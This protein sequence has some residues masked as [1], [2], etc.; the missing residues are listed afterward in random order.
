MKQLQ[1]TSFL[2]FL[3]LIALPAQSAPETFS[4]AKAQTRDHVYFDQTEQGTFYCGCEWRWT[5]RSGG[6]VDLDSCGYEIRAQEHRAIRIEWEH[7]VPASNF[8]RARQCW[9]DGGRSNCQRTD[10]VFSLME[11]D[12]HNLAP[13]IGEVNADRSNYNFSVLPTAPKQHGACDFKVDFKDRAAE[14]RDEVKGQVARAYFY[15]FDRYD[16]QMSRQQEQLLMAWDRQFPVSAWELERDRRISPLMG[17]SNPF[18]TGERSWSRDHRN[19]AEGIYVALPERK[20]PSSPEYDES[21]RGNRNS[22]IYHL[23]S[24]C[25]S[26]N[27]V[28]QRNIVEFAT[29]EQAEAAGYRKA[30]NCR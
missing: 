8:G 9:Q 21:I 5:G 20:A 26:Y 25:P 29:E 11:A 30:G 3:S 1:F 17:H 15:M 19:T 13:S 16:L 28:S 10:P 2:I 27:K 4:Q 22:N 23:P 18:V 7:L 6:R 24:G 14:P 12:M